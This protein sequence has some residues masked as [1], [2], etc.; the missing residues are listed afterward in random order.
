MSDVPQ[1]D[2]QFLG[3][4]LAIAFFRDSATKFLIGFAKSDTA[5]AMIYPDQFGQFLLIHVPAEIICYDAAQV[6]WDLYD[7][8]RQRND[9]NGLRALWR[10]SRRS[11]LHDIM[12]LEQRLRL[13]RDAVHPLPKRFEALADLHCKQTPPA[14]IEPGPHGAHA[15]R[16]GI[17]E[18]EELLARAATTMNIYQTLRQQADQVI[19]HLGIPQKLVARY[20]PLG[21]GVDVQGAIAAALAS[22]EGIY[23]SSE[24]LEYMAQAVEVRYREASQVLIHDEH[25]R[26]VFVG[27]KGLVRRREDGLPEADRNFLQKWLRHT[28]DQ[29]RDTHNA[30]W[31]EPVDETGNLSMTPEHWGVLLRCSPTL[32]AWD[33]LQAAAEAIS[34]SRSANTGP[35]HPNYQVFPELRSSGPDLAYL[36]SMGGEFVPRPDFK[37]VTVELDHL[38]LRSFAVNCEHRYHRPDVYLAWMF[39]DGLIRL[40]ILLLACTNTKLRNRRFL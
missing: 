15:Q 7:L 25:A 38:E 32:R 26:H 16:G 1:W 21:L 17:P 30:R 12:L 29:L 18:A 10:F 28:F 22:R 11:R 5:S 13:I 34:W 37:F 14:A 9:E 27:S 6:H 33:T 4:R 8:L 20:G 40:N 19:D 35:V 39:R 31:L 3:E 23:L 24:S 36:R 2:G